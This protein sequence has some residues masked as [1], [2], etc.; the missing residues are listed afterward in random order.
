MRLIIFLFTLLSASF[1]KAH[2]ISSCICDHACYTDEVANLKCDPKVASFKSV[3]LPDAS[4]TIMEGIIATNQQFPRVHQ[5]EFKITRVPQKANKPT[6][7]DPGAIG[8]AVNGVPIFDPATQGPINAKTGKR[9][10]TL[11]EG[12]LDDCGGHAG[13]G[14]D[15]HYHIAPICLIEELGEAHIEQMK[16]PI[17]YAMDGYPIHALGWFSKENDV[18]NKL[19]E[20]RGMTDENGRYFYN[21]MKNDS[22]DVLNCL[23]G[24][25]QKFSKDKWTHRKDKF[26]DNYVGMPVKFK[27]DTYTQTDQKADKCYIMTGNLNKEQILLTDGTTQQVKNKSGSI[28]YCNS[29]C[30]GVF[31]EAEKKAS[32]RGRAII[33]DEIL[34]SC[35]ASLVDFKRFDI[36]PYRGPRQKVSKKKK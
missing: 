7:A 31:F 25:P 12:E 28:F 19:D 15:Y 36:S 9:P 2:E 26:G 23:T 17:G 21:V 1:P 11:Y 33:Y 4:H 34:D 24:R 16:R 13:R 22:W 8:V 14:D 35:P 29:K 6:Y 10:H 5:Y 27:I 18:E 32:I 3:G 20:C 30:Y